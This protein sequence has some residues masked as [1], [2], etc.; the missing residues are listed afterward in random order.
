M[1]RYG[2]LG[3]CFFL[4]EQLGV[5]GDERTY[6]NVVSLRAVTSTDGMTLI[7]LIYHLIFYLM[8]QIKLLIK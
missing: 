8:F 3:Q 5:M 2:K 7:G 6:E 4:L 1:I